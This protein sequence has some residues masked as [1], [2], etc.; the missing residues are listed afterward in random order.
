MKEIKHVSFNEIILISAKERFEED[1]PLTHYVG[2]LSGDNGRDST[3]LDILIF[4]CS[5]SKDI[6]SVVDKEINTL[7]DYLVQNPEVR[8]IP[9][10]I[11]FFL[12]LKEEI[13]DTSLRHDPPEELV[14]FLS[15]HGFRGLGKDK[16]IF[17]S[18]VSSLV[19]K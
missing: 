3:I 15:G 7:K 19:E 17:L 16:A 13:E 4:N 11:V 6:P 18:G 5:S 2:S 12:K 8:E 14:N 9:G 10:Q 1:Y